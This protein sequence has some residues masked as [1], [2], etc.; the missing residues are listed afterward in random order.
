MSQGIQLSQRLTQTLVLS[1]QLQQSLHL[2]QAP[3]LEL[4]AMVE[5]ELQQNPVLDEIPVTEIEQKRKSDENGEAP[6]TSLDP[7]EPPKDVLFDPATEKASSAPVDDFQTE[8]NRLVQMDQE[9]RDH[10]AQANGPHRGSEEDMEKRQFLFD[11]LTRNVSLQES[12]LE[13]LRF[14]DQPASRVP[15]AEFIIG[16]LD[17]FGYLKATL[18]EIAEATHVSPD[19]VRSVLNFVQTFDPPGVAAR[20]LRE[21]LLL[22]LERAGRQD[23]TEYK[24]IQDFW[25]ALSRRRIPE[26]AS[27]VGLDLEQA[28]AALARI[29]RLDPKPGR[30]FLADDEQFI[31]PEVFVRKVDG[32]YVVTIDETHLPRLRIS[33]TYKDIMSKLTV[34][35]ESFDRAFAESDP[36]LASFLAAVREALA[37]GDDHRTLSSLRTLVDHPSLTEPQRRAVRSLS[38]QVEERR[39]QNET[40]TYIRDKITAAKFLIRSLDQRQQ[41]ILKIAREIVMRQREFLDQGVAHLKPMTMAQVAEV[42]GVHETTVSRAVSG[43]YMETPQGIFEMKYFFA[44]GLATA[45]GELVAN[46]SVKEMVAEIFHNE[47]PGKPLSDDE[48]AKMLKAKG[49]NIAR[50]TVAKYRMELGILSSTMRKVYSGPKPAAR[51]AAA[52]VVEETGEDEDEGGEVM[53]SAAVEAPDSAR[54]PVPVPVPDSPAPPL[55]SMPPIPPPEQPMAGTAS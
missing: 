40:R 12:L 36:T 42:V 21:C 38:R 55:P 41:T 13:Q 7:T 8:F 2:L 52:A 15:V 45:S 29:S 32:D 1:P 18:E 51:P 39:A 50:R 33:N 11:S 54:V 34:E 20:D 37:A 19:E 22:Q 35:T 14:A 5:K 30:E 48:V 24:I 3:I 25:D 10:Y 53:E 28:Q 47:D 44:T 43:K 46:T 4:K 31:V 23:S 6:S 16:N 49:L 17:D 26:I 9:W 27:G